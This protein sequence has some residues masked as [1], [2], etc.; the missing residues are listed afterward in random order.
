VLTYDARH[1][2]Q[3]PPPKVQD[4][5]LIVDGRCSTSP[6]KIFRLAVHMGL[7][8]TINKDN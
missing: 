8:Q 1:S 5:P 2:R 7:Q 3:Q 4:P 6:C